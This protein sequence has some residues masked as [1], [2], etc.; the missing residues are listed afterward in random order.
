MAD[1]QKDMIRVVL[2][3][4]GKE[5]RITKI[6]S[7]L[8]GMQKIVGGYIEV[9]YPFDEEVCIICNEEGKINGLSANRGIKDE[10]YRVVDIIAGPCFICDCSGENFGSLSDEQAERYKEK[11]LLPERFM[12]MEGNIYAMPYR[13]KSKELER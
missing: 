6:D 10:E 9:T 4:P 8:E 7:S 13:P 3:E 2:L 11:F 12:R 1:L 5:A